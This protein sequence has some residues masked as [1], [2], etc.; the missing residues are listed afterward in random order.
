[1]TKT[2][3]TFIKDLQESNASFTSDKEVI[4]A[5]NVAWVLA[6]QNCLLQGGG[7]QELI[8]LAQ[9]VL[10]NSLTMSDAGFRIVAHTTNI[11]PSAPVVKTAIKQG[12]FGNDELEVFRKKGRPLRWSTQSGISVLENDNAREIV[13]CIFRVKGLYAAH[14]VMECV[15][16]GLDDPKLM[17]DFSLLCNCLEM[18]I[19]QTLPA[20][21]IL[22][23]GPTK[24]LIDLTNGV[25][26]SKQSLRTWT[27]TTDFDGKTMHAL[28][29]FDFA[30]Q[31][32]EKQLAVAACLRIGELFPHAIVGLDECKA[33]M[34]YPSDTAA[35]AYNKKLLSYAHYSGS[36][37]GVSDTFDKATDIK[38][39]YKQACIALVRNTNLQSGIY[40]F[41]QS[42][43]SY[44]M[45][46]QNRDD[47]LISYC[48]KHCIPA[49]LLKADKAAKTDD[50]R[51]LFEYLRG[52]RKSSAVAN[53]LHMHRNTLLYRIKRIEEN[54]HID[55]DDWS[56]RE[57]LIVE[58]RAMGY[59]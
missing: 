14:L 36:H 39:A 28:A 58:Y 4:S 5:S 8:D 24:T 16:R 40:P 33:V 41:K 59:E 54:Y 43:A 30:Y 45:S 15:G 25:T 23:Q 22:N 1:M 11:K 52:E 31:Q 44:V 32:E 10:K 35:K 2:V 51:I 38:F 27:R 3:Q 57:R 13:E 50:C 56:T 7:Y 48:L 19:K 20:S 46:A 55:L 49:R 26:V 18:H 9:D 21:S 29:L 47:E 42:F 6:M 37:I 17:D 12:F 34:V 53:L